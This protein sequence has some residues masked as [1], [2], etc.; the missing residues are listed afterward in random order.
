MIYHNTKENVMK[1][2]NF[3]LILRIA[4]LFYLM[5]STSIFA[6]LKDN[7]EVQLKKRSMSG[8]RMG[9]T[10]IPGDSPMYQK[11]KADEM[12]R[13]VS[14]FGWHFEWTIAPEYFEGPEF[15]VEY[16]PLISGV[17]Y[18]KFIPSMTLAFGIRF[19]F[20]F[21]FGMGPNMQI[22]SD[23]VTTSL[24]IAVGQSID[25]GGI[26][27]P[28]NLAYVKNPKGDRVTFLFGYAID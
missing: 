13:L 28:L 8:P 27:I 26:R 24:V 25:F 3:K 5:I 12:G 15:V 11:A 17:E 1:T 10:Y 19:P 20:G 4:T 9:F 16:I 22:T 18:N 21:E 2:S 14:Q 6:Q 23:N 7:E